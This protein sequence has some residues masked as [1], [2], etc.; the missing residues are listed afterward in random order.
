MPIGEAKP[1][2]DFSPGHKVQDQFNKPAIIKYYNQ[3][4]D[5]QQWPNILTSLIM[6]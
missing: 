4:Q 3:S 5:L 6:Q 2:G 1:T